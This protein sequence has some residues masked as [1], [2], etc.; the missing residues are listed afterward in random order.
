ME[1]SNDGENKWEVDKI[2][3][4][5]KFRNKTEYLVSWKNFPQHESTWEAEHTL[6]EDVPQLIKEFNSKHSNNIRSRKNKN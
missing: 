1:I 2:I 5:R 3:K 6:N 4:K